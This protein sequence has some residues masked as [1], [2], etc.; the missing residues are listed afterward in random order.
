MEAMWLEGL[1][2]TKARLKAENLLG[3][4]TR[5]VLSRLVAKAKADVKSAAPRRLGTL[6]GSVKGQLR[7]GKRG[8]YGVVTISARGKPYYGKKAEPE[9][10]RYWR[11]LNWDSRSRHK[12]WFDN[13]RAQVAADV[14]REKQT[15]AAEIAAKWRRR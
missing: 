3:D 14:K 2:E 13:A 9:G 12:G 5:A 15:L 8:S 4:P 7:G 10:Y 1:A 11:R 6:A